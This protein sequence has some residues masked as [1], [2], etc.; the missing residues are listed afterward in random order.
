MKIHPKPLK[1]KHTSA[2]YKKHNM[3]RKTISK[4]K[5]SMHL[6]NTQKH[7][8]YKKNHP[9]PQNSASNSKTF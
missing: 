1:K 7:N 6:N 9:E 3:Y 8:M 5:T 4:Q 2:K